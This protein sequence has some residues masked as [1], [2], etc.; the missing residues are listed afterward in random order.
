MFLAPAPV[1]CY[2]ALM[3]SLREQVESS[4]DGLARNV[5]SKCAT[6]ARPNSPHTTI[7]DVMP[8]MPFTHMLITEGLLPRIHNAALPTIFHSS[9]TVPMTKRAS[10]RR[11]SDGNS[12]RELS[13]LS[14]VGAVRTGR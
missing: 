12:S 14:G 11:L 7:H 1:V 4:L 13:P 5:F 9:S 6:T 3:T 8:P 10:R 2:Y